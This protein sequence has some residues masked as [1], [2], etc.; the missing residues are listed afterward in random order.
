MVYGIVF[1]YEIEDGRL[2]F[3]PDG[4]ERVLWYSI[5][6]KT[7]EDRPC[8]D[9]VCTDIAFF[10]PELWNKLSLMGKYKLDIA[11]RTLFPKYKDSSFVK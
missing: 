2:Y 3:I 1:D 11:V 8:P 5:D 9:N 6:G 4:C 10:I 7:F